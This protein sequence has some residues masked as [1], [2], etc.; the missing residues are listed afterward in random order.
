MVDHAQVLLP[1]KVLVEGEIQNVEG[2]IGGQLDRTLDLPKRLATGHIPLH[3]NSL[4]RRLSLYA[5]PFTRTRRS[6]YPRGCRRTGIEN[7]AAAELGYPI[8]GRGA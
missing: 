3:W 6:A 4:S 1:D 8:L 7:A 2:M 5:M